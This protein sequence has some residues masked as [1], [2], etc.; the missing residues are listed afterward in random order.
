MK[1]KLAAEKVFKSFRR[2]DGTVIEILNDINITVN[3]NELLVILG[4]GQCGKTVF[5]KLVAGLTSLGGEDTY[6]RAA[7]DWA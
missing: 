5:L 3:E 6:G 4:P 7:G 1:Q 2:T